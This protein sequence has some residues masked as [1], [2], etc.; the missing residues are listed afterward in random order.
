MS[1]EAW[2][3][4][5]EIK[6]TSLARAND[7]N[8]K[9]AIDILE[10]VKKFII[11]K[12]LIL[13]GG[14]AIDIA[15][16]LKGQQLYSDDEPPDYDMFSPNGIEDSY[17][18]ADILYELGYEKSQSRRGFHLQTM[19]VG[20]DQIDAADINSV[21]QSAFDRLP[22]L[23]YGGLRIIHPDYQRIDM[24][25]ALSFPFDGAPREFIFHRWTKDTKRFNLI[26]E[27]YPIDVKA[28]IPKHKW[29][30]ATLP[31][32]E[33]IQPMIK[34]PTLALHGFAAF[35]IYKHM[36][37]FSKMSLKLLSSNK[38]ALYSPH[39]FIS[40]A[41]SH[42]TKINKDDV[43]FSPFIDALPESFINKNMEI[44]ITKYRRLAIKKI[45]I[46]RNYIAIVNPH[47]LLAWFAVT[48]IKTNKKW[49][50]L[51]YRELLDLIIKNK[52]NNLFKPTLE[53]MGAENISHMYSA[54][55][56]DYT[57]IILQNKMTIPDKLSYENISG[58]P[59]KNY[60]PSKGKPHPEFTMCKLFQ[61]D[62]K[63]YNNA[64]Q[65]S[66]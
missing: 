16:R 14:M 2:I 66:I 44:I 60:V 51:Y 57:N 59:K 49:Y 25:I 46:G 61:R 62:G 6:F 23:E 63:I 13:F 29:K 38:I 7:I 53:S 35:E 21:P 36:G 39:D 33:F 8:N 11:D 17:E 50:W 24:H 41:S 42:I 45:K 32:G 5:N 9:K 12:K 65:D 47:Y 27:L 30:I 18:L 1:L 10:I 20:V 22:F 15:F 31:C 3:N 54:Q 43:H 64:C 52:S 37:N 48:A 28:K 58:L 34:E 26:N 40:F 56:I 55:L 4:K 19:K